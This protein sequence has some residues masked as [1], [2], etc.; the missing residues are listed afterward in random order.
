MAGNLKLCIVWTLKHTQLP[1]FSKSRN[2]L[3]WVCTIEHRLEPHSKGNK[4]EKVILNRNCLLQEMV[5][6]K[7]TV[8]TGV[9]SSKSAATCT[10]KAAKQATTLGKSAEYVAQAQHNTPRYYRIP[11]LG[12]DSQG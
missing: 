11:S 10:G 12:K 4:I 3:C 6:T 9:G 8:C 7:Q 1:L 2:G 5:T